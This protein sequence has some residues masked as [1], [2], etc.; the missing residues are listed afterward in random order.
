LRKEVLGKSAE[1]IL[2]AAGL[3]RDYPVLLIVVP[4]DKEMAKGQYGRE[5]LAPF[6]SLFTVK[7]ADEGFK[8]AKE[9]LQHEGQG[10]TAMIHTQDQE[11]AERFGIEMPASR[12][13]VNT[14]GAQGCIGLGTGL[15]PSFTLGCGTL[16]K[17]STTDNVTYT[18]LLNIKRMAYAL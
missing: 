13:L 2:H 11:L 5:K 17:T 9:I 7:D 14:P 3:Q 6:L 15:L 12:I 1:S 16:G 4:L 10:H 8:L 18:N